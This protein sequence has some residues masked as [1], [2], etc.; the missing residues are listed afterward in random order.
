MSS[1]HLPPPLTSKTLQAALFHALKRTYETS[2]E[3]HDASVGDDTMTFGIHIWKSG[4]HFLEPAVEA[5]GGTTC[6][7]N[8]SQ[9]IRFGEVELRHHKLGDNETDNPFASF[10]NHAGPAARMHGRA[11]GIQLD[12]PLPK[13]E[14]AMVS[15]YLDW[16]LGS[17]GNP[18][19]GL[20]AVRLHAVGEHRA[21]DGTI[22]RWEDVFTIFDASEGIAMPLDPTIQADAARA[23]VEVTQEPDVELEA[24]ANQA[25]DLRHVDADTPTAEAEIIQEPDI[26][27]Q[28]DS[29]AP[30]V[31][32]PS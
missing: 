1:R 6:V 8:Q 24:D 5:V 14:P 29:E 25:A 4:I 17:Y 30:D 20:R 28:N 31:E 13:D 2:Q 16:V 27:L 3:R 26:E 23:D 15:V 9:A 19:D 18:E 32:H 12:L 7:T 10:P 11:A 21:L 22:N